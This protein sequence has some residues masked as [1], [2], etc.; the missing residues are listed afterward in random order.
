M[1]FDPM[2]LLAAFGGGLFGAAVGG[3]PAF[4]L[5]GLAAVVGAGINLATGDATFSNTIAWGPILGPQISFAGGAAAAVYAQRIGKLA[6][7]RDIAT[8]LMGLDRPDVLL[9]GGLFGAIGYL[10]WLAFANIPAIGDTGATN[11]IALSI[12]V[13][14][15]IARVAFGKTGPFGRVRLGDNRW[16]PSEVASWLPWQSHPNQLLVLGLGAGIA[17]SWTTIQVPALAAIW[18]GFAAAGLIFLQYGTKVPVW[19]HIALASEQV[20]V[21]AG[22]DIWWGVTFAVMAAF[23]GEFYACLF[24]AHG[25]SHID[26]PS[27]SLA[28]TF[29]IMAVLAYVGAFELTG[30]PVI[31]IGIGVAVVGY[32]VMSFLRRRP[33]A[34]VAVA[35]LSAAV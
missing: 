11:P 21:I 35:P 8:A 1:T 13:N 2:W 7:G 20:I 15:L 16:R 31:A 17:V 25:D 33:N 5:C 29:T 12:V 24:T 30:A 26:P 10:L 18:F 27:A 9:V 28:T 4:I 3:L 32:G 19:H 6:N 22:G 14:A 34:A 23:I